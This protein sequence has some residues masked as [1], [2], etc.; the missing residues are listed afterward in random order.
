MPYTITAHE[1]RYFTGNYKYQTTSNTVDVTMPTPTPTPTPNLCQPEVCDGLDNNCNG[2]VDETY[3]FDSDG[4]STCGG[5]CHDENA[6]IYPGAPLGYCTGTSMNFRDWN[7][8]GQDDYIEMNC[9]SP[10]LLDVEGDKFRLTDGNGGV[11]FDLNSDGHKEKLSWTAAGSDDAW[12]VLDRNNNGIIDN[13]GELF[14]NFTPQPSP[15]TGEELNGFLALAEF[16]KTENGGNNDGVINVSDTVFS[17][18]RLWQDIN[19]NGISETSE[20][21]T[22]QQLDIAKLELRYHESKLTDE[23]GNQ[24][25]Y[26]AKVWDANKTKAGR[27]AW[28]VF[29]VF[30]GKSASANTSSVKEFSLVSPSSSFINFLVSKDLLVHKKQSKCGR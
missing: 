25:K 24:F 9:G 10:I 18:L 20:L 17:S 2:L 21:K 1:F 13:G 8:N 23:Y 29:L 15:P 27:W 5:D 22:L 4:W 3:D 26:R 16:D 11:S 19:H 6:S 28:D 30:A 12:L 7:C 14:G